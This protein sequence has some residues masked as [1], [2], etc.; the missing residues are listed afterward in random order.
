[1]IDR[2]A[3]VNNGGFGISSVGAKLHTTQR[4]ALA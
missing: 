1:M 4:I 2:S 3:F